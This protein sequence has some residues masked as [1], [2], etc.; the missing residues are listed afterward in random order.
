[1]PPLVSCVVLAHDQLDRTRA[2]LRSLLL[3]AHR[4]LEIVAVDNG[5][6]DGTGE[7]LNGFGKEAEAAGVSL[8]I[9]STGKN[10]GCSTARNLGLSLARGEVVAFMDNDTAL[11]TR[12]WVERFLEAFRDPSVAMIG[13]KLLFPWVPFP[14]EC[15]G[16]S[17]SRDGWVVYRGRG[18]PRETPAF[19]APCEV[20]ALISAWIASPRA[21]LEKAGGFDEHFNPIQFE[22]IDLCYRLRVK[23]GKV[24]YLPSVEHYHF[25]GGTSTKTAGLNFRYST[26]R[27]GMKFKAR[28][29]AVVENENGPER[30][31]PW[32]D[33]EK[34]PPAEP[35][36]II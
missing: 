34:K 11:R 26:I 5:S 6:Q 10:E 32:R 30:A 12:G 24:L 20:Q 2:C 29:K 31:P 27:N 4:P 13:P 33:I 3:S 18:E 8:R 15:A 35:L 7:W 14:V 1:M 21:W 28:W 16:C 25:E 17:V 22:D 19:S 23:G 9:H 36:P